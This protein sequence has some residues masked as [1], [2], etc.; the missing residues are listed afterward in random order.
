MTHSDI[1]IEET[2]NLVGRES[3]ALLR[4]RV[5]LNQEGEELSFLV[6]HLGIPCFDRVGA[7]IASDEDTIFLSNAMGAVDGLILDRGVPPAIV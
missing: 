4:C 7:D 1:Q 6:E 2:K 5:P 3:Q